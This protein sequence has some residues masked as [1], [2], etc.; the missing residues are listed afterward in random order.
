MSNTALTEAAKW[1][2]ELMDAE[3]KGRKD[4]E[5]LVRYRLAK[6]IGVAE[7]Y[8]FRLQYKTREMTDVRGSVYRALMLGRR[9]YGLAVTVGDAVYEKEKALADG[10]NSKMARLAA[11]VAGSKNK[12]AVRAE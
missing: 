2:E 3:W 5:N 11:A 12:K 8:L 1:T 10:R 6:A 7:S 4:R 9:A